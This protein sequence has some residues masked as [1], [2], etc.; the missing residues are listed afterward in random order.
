MATEW[1]LGTVWWLKSLAVMPST[2]AE[3]VSLWKVYARTL[4]RWFFCSGLAVSDAFD[5]D[6]AYDGGFFRNSEVA[7]FWIAGRSFAFVASWRVG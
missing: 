4:R 2:E 6:V 3:V 1:V 7:A 5:S